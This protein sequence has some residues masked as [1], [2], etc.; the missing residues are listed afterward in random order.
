[1]K[2][3]SRLD[4]SVYEDDVEQIRRKYDSLSKGEKS[5]FLS[6]LFLHYG[7]KTATMVGK[8]SGRFDFSKLEIIAIKSEFGM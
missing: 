8:F 5:K 1:M 2:E 4:A 3:I 6:S 7:L